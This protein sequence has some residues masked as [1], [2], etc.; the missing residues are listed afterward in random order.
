MNTGML[1]VKDRFIHDQGK[2]KGSDYLISTA[3]CNIYFPVRDCTTVCLPHD[4][5]VC[6]RSAF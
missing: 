6:I 3:N 5:N 1:L 2:W 4:E